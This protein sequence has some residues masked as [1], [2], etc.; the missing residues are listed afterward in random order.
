MVAV[1]MQAPYWARPSACM[2]WTYRSR[3]LAEL[4]D[5][6]WIWEV[7]FALNQWQSSRTC[8]VDGGS[9][10]TYAIIFS[11]LNFVFIPS[12]VLSHSGYE[13][14]DSVT[15]GHTHSTNDQLKVQETQIVEVQGSYRVM[16][17]LL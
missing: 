10:V 15:M 11:C 13:V 1:T 17:C 16:C 5:A 9:K 6:S 3:I 14:R 12:H 2:Q 8:V 4:I 7:A